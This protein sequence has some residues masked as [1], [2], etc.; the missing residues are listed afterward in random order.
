MALQRKNHPASAATV[1][2]SSSE[3]LVSA[4]KKGLK[5]GEVPIHGRRR[6]FG[7][8]RK[9]TDLLYGLLFLKTMARTW[10]R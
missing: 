2:P 8:S 6:E 1:R 3:V 5:I 7:V 4:A 10:W 9:R